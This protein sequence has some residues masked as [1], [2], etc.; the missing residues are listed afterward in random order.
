MDFNMQKQ[1]LICDELW[2]EVSTQQSVETEITLPDYC[3]DIKRILKCIM[4][5][6]ITNVSVSGR[7][8]SVLR[9]V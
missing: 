6:G 2:Q 8:S 1:K 7:G 5:P 4:T 3:S 9:F